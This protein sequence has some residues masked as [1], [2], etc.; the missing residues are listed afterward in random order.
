MDFKHFLTC[1]VLDAMS[2]L[3][4]GW[5]ALSHCLFYPLWGNALSSDS[6]LNMGISLD[7]FLGNGNRKW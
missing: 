2:R 3:S 4:R 1:L 5:E 7:C 6:I